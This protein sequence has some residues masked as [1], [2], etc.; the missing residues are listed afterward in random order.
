MAKSLEEILKSVN[1]EKLDDVKSKME[2]GDLTNILESI[3]VDKAQKMI[4]DMGLSEKTKNVNL[5][6]LISEIKKNPD[7][8][9]ELKKLF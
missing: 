7:I 1:Q 4:T 9:K 8:V 5:T 6:K 3:D 2:K